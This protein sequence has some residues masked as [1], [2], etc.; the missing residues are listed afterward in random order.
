MFELLQL[1]NTVQITEE[2]LKTAFRKAAM[3]HHPDR[4]GD[5]EIFM[6]IK[7]SYESLKEHIQQLSRSVQGEIINPYYN[8]ENDG[9][10]GYAPTASGYWTF[11]VS[12]T[13]Y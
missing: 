10:T 8:F 7:E 1:D 5:P 12:S 11:T 6:K 2:S 9:G 3:K 4:G 13:N